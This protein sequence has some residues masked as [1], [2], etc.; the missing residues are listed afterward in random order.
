L[1]PSQRTKTGGIYWQFVFPAVTLYLDP[2]IRPRAAR[3]THLVIVLD[4]EKQ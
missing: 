2:Q 1:P 3:H 4:R